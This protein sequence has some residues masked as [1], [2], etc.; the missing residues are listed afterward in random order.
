V[1]AGRPSATLAPARVKQDGLAKR[2]SAVRVGLPEL[3]VVL[4][5]AQHGRYRFGGKRV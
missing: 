4:L 1:F 3:V 5:D 2:V